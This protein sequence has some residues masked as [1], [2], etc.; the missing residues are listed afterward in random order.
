MSLKDELAPD[1]S[2]DKA[3]QSL[4][5]L[6]DALLW[7]GWVLFRVTSKL[8]FIL[9][10]ELNTSEHKMFLDWIHWH[11]LLLKF[12]LEPVVFGKLTLELE[13]TYGY[14]REQADQF[15]CLKTVLMRQTWN[16]EFLA[17]KA[18]AYWVK[19]WISYTLFTLQNMWI[20]TR[21]LFQ[22]YTFLFW[23]GQGI[24]CHPT[25]TGSQE[26]PSGLYVLQEATTLMW[27][28]TF[29]SIICFK[30]H[31]CTPQ[32]LLLY[33]SAAC[34]NCQT[35][36]VQMSF[37]W[38]S[39]CDLGAH[40]PQQARWGDLW[41]LHAFVWNRALSVCIPV[42]WCARLGKEACLPFRLERAAIVMR[43]QS[44]V[45]SHLPVRVWMWPR[46]ACGPT[47]WSIRKLT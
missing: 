28:Q 5:S 20:F 3:A 21:F 23:R 45:G 33:P 35:R 41:K 42:K 38:A 24:L 26:E 14:L 1:G 43:M 11:V 31:I 7:E 25:N 6:L 27:C 46:H 15:L 32:N 8:V 18:T 2:C 39:V 10:S 13:M 37:K 19:V 44:I 40:A 29:I 47:A 22:L 9:P 36:T 12:N 16:V 17:D 30:L 34:R 4:L